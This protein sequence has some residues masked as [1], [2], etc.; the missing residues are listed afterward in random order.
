VLYPVIGMEVR[1]DYSG[2]SLKFDV[3]ICARYLYQMHANTAMWSRGLLFVQLSVEI[4]GQ[5]FHETV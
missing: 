3:D 2:K 1:R 5:I 4:T